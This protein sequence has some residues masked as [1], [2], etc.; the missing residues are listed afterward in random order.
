MKNILKIVNNSIKLLSSINDGTNRL[1]INGVEI[2]SSSWVGT[3]YYYYGE[4]K[5][6]KIAEN[7]GNVH[8]IKLSA[9]ECQMTHRESPSAPVANLTFYGTCSSAADAQHKVASV[10]SDFDLIMGA[11]VAIKFANTNTYSATAQNLVTLNVN[12][13][14]ARGIYYGE[15]AAPTGTNTTAFGRANYINYYLYNGDYW[16][17]DGSSADNDT[18]YSAMSVAEGKAGTATS[19]RVMRADYLKQIIQY[20]GEAK[21]G[22]KTQADV[23][24][25]TCPTAAAEPKKVVTLTDATNF[26]LRT[27][28]TILVKFTYTHTAGSVA[29]TLNVDG[30]GD[31]SIWFNTAVAGANTTWPAGSAGQYQKYVY[32]GTYWVWCGHSSDNNTTYSNMSVAEGQAGTATNGRIMRADYL[33]QIIPTHARE[34]LVEKTNSEY[35]ALSDAEKTNGDAYYIPDYPATPININASGVGF[36]PPGVGGLTATNVRD[37]LYQL[38]DRFSWKLCASLTAANPS[39][40]LPSSFNELYL[41]VKPISNNDFYRTTIVPY[42]ALTNNDAGYYWGD[43]TFQAR[44]V[45]SRTNISFSAVDDGG[46][47]RYQ[48]ATVEVYYRY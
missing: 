29:P 13:T 33:K 1:I 43:K 20:Y 16:V 44:V 23:F 3:G 21:L 17:W 24:I 18:T 19:S 34:I 36:S 42:V 31:K 6:G 14:G 27:G 5:I 8:C 11:R 10:D 47:N 22:I 45:I 39:S 48:T 4:I 41:R 28:V 32:D 26:T 2:P 7:S 12:N 30:T 35:Q 37:A 46:V 38:D 25:G 15:T 9:T 40:A